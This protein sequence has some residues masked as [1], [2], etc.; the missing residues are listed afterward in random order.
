VSWAHW[1][2]LD[3]ACGGRAAVGDR[4]EP[5]EVVERGGHSEVRRRPKLIGANNDRVPFGIDE[6]FKANQ[7]SV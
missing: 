3:A 4:L 6:N 7:G 2:R 1:L 5:V